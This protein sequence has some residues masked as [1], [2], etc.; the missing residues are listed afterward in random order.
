[1]DTLPDLFEIESFVTRTDF[2]KHKAG[3]IILLAF[4]LKLKRGDLGEYKRHKLI[5]SKR[6]K[7]G[8]T[9]FGVASAWLDFSREIEV[10]TGRKECS[11]SYE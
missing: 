4:S 1:M 11:F 8:L 10:K 5:K 6:L 9:S 2:G 3:G 7:P